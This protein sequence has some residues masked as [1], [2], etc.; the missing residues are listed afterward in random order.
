MNLIIIA[1]ARFRQ[2]K[3]ITW[4]LFEINYK[5]VFKVIQ[6]KIFDN[7]MTLSRDTFFIWLGSS[8]VR[9]KWALSGGENHQKPHLESNSRIGRSHTQSSLEGDQSNLT[10]LALVAELQHIMT[11]FCEKFGNKMIRL[12]FLAILAT[13]VLGGLSPVAA[14]S[15]VITSFSGSSPSQLSVRDLG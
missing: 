12:F 9:F 10:G 13:L 6:T 15:S 4:K 1:I 11:D 8:L 2:L 5:T 7:L 14:G 3:S